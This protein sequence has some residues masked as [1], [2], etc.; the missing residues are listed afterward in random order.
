MDAIGAKLLRLRLDK[1][2]EA[3]VLTLVIGDVQRINNATL[4]IH[5]FWVAPLE[6]ALGIWLLWR[7]VGAPSMT[8]LGI[9]LGMYLSLQ[10]TLS[11]AR[12]VPY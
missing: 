11:R 9:A 1:E 5:D 8:V 10:V 4:F 7:Q 2:A 12:T 6:V 3:K